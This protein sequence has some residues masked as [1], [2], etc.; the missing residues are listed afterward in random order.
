MIPKVDSIP[1]AASAIPYRPI[2]GFAMGFSIPMLETKNATS[3]AIPTMM[4]GIAVINIIL[5][6]I[7]LLTKNKSFALLGVFI[8]FAVAILFVIHMAVTV[9]DA[10]CLDEKGAVSQMRKQ[11]IIRYVCVCAVVALCAYYRIADPIFLVISILTI[12]AGAY[13]QPTVHRLLNRR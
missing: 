3:T 4:I 5:A 10:L 1:T 8:G 6:V 2:C 11:M 9:D 7:A 12:K 13:L